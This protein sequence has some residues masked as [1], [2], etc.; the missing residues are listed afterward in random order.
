MVEEV[1]VGGAPVEHSEHWKAPELV[2]SSFKYT[3]PTFKKTFSS[4][5]KRDVLQRLKDVINNMTIIIKG[6]IQAT[7]EAVKCYLSLN[8]KFCK[9]TSPGVKTGQAIKFQSEV[10]KSIDISEPGNQFHVG[11]KQIVQQIEEFQHSGSGWVVDHLQHLDLSTCF[12]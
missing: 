7:V 1:Q 4:N 2:E 6:Q 10:F 9:F 12:L 8:I 11:Y 5:N 3:A